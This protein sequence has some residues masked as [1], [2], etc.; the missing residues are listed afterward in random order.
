MRTK[1]KT[2]HWVY[3]LCTRVALLL[4]IILLFELL[5][6]FYYSV[7]NIIGTI[8]LSCTILQ[9]YLQCVDVSSINVSLLH[10]LLFL[11]AVVLHIHLKI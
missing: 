8:L 9:I 11:V 7:S 5:L 10:L 4:Y 1:R 6:F 2:R 3:L